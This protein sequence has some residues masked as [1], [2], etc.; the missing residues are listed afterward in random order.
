MRIR[1]EGRTKGNERGGKGR[2]TCTWRRH[3]KLSLLNRT[4]ATQSDRPE[5]WRGKWGSGKREGVGVGEKEQ[6]KGDKGEGERERRVGDEERRVGDEE[7][8]E[9]RRNI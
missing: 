6:E 5:G 1:M 9:R 8:R 2:E 7:R 3:H 4:A